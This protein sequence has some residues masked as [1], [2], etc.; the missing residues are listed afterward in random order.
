MHLT[1]IMSRNIKFG[2]KIAYEYAICKTCVEKIGF[3]ST[4]LKI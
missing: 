3:N 4:M 2:T 1:F